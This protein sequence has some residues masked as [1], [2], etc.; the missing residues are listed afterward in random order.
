[1]CIT[2]HAASEK[3]AIYNINYSLLKC[4]KIN[5][6]HFTRIYLYQIYMWSV[7]FSNIRVFLTSMIS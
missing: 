1:M 2:A 4:V 5:V 6:Q 7:L 3:F